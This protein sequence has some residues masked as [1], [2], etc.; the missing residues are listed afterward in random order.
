MIILFN[1]LIVKISQLIKFGSSSLFF[2]DII[3][4][5]IDVEALFSYWFCSLLFGKILEDFICSWFNI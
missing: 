4:I 1:Y 2:H 5:I 3:K